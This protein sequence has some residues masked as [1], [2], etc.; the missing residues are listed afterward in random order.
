MAHMM[1]RFLSKVVWG[2]VAVGALMAILLIA[3]PAPA[4]AE[5]PTT[6]PAGPA[7]DQVERILTL[8]KAERSSLIVAQS[9]T[10]QLSDSALTMMLAKV[11]A[12]PALSN[13]EFMSLD[14]PSFRN[15]V[16][17]ADRWSA[18]PVRLT[19]Y[20]WYVQEL[21]AGVPGEIG[22]TRDW[23]QGK[24][25]WRMDVT[26]ADGSDPRS[27]VLRIFSVVDPFAAGALPKPSHNVDGE[28]QYH[29]KVPKVDL[30]GVF[31]KV[32]QAEDRDTEERTRR[33]AGKGTITLNPTMR[34]YPVVL[35]WQFGRKA[36]WTINPGRYSSGAWGMLIGGLA[37]LGLVFYMM[38]RV[39]RVRRRMGQ[40]FRRL[41]S[42]YRPLRD[43]DTDSD[44]DDQ[45]DDASDA[46]DPAV[47]AAAEAYRRQRAQEQANG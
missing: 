1:P 39:S 25:V 36:G 3:P 45:M 21:T 43:Q 2:S 11:A 29:R 20:V 16:K 8:T 30:A 10:T 47:T 9:R 27:Q 17:S 46:I 34:S 4:A 12:L 19:V 42:Q 14:R 22:A 44:S 40:P 31:Y 6:A 32:W 15:L 38:R 35:A 24:K 33:D 28:L 18:Q 23:P 41:P 5:D 37:L 7:L 13:D 26:D